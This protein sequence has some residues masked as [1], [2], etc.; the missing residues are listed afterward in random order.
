MPT[1]CRIRCFCLE[2]QPRAYIACDIEMVQRNADR[3]ISGFKSRD[4]ITSALE[5]LGLET[6][7]ARR[8]KTGHSLLFIFLANEENHN[9]L[10]NA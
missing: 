8:G 5:N 4:S 7:A 2:P 1:T 9:S 10:I 6:L 3:F